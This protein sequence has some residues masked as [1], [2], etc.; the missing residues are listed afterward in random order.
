MAKIVTLPTRAFG[1]EPGLPDIAAL[2]GWVA[3]H[4]GTKADLMA[5]RLDASLTPQLDAGITAPCAGGL[6]LRERVLGDLTGLNEERNVVTGEIAFEG[7]G[8]AADAAMLS[9]RKKD[10]WFSLPAPHAL[11]ITDAYY[12]DEDELQEAFAAACRRMMREMRDAG[13]GGHV[14]ICTHI[15]ESELAALAQ[16]KVFFFLPEASGKDLETLLEY[17]RVVAVRPSLLEEVSRLIDEYDISRLIIMDPDDKAIKTALAF[18]DPD[19]ISA[20]GYCTT[21]C[22]TY[23]QAL[24]ASAVYR[25]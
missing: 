11:G 23:W 6:F 12:G 22:D 1:A 3:D 20:G 15:V 10:L 19:R 14:L 25:K 13:I 2:V 16:K 4:R 18:C 7:T 17:Q 9:P 24:A 5:Y 8:L 21:S